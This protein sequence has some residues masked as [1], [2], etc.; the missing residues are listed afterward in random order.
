[1]VSRYAESEEAQEHATRAVEEGADALLGFL[2]GC[3]REYVAA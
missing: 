1:M 2:D 3:Y